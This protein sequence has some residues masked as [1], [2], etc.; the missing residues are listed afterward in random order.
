MFLEKIKSPEDLKKIPEK[1][2][3]VL[4]GEIRQKIIDTVNKNGG[5]MASNLGIVELTVALHRVFNS[6]Q[7]AII[8]DVS[9]QSYAHKLL[10]GRY[11]EFDTIRQQG[12]LSGFTR[13]SESS[14][15]Y[16]DAGHASSS[17]SSA[18]G[19]L[20]AWELQ[21]RNDKVAAVI[22]DGA[23]TGGMAFEAL[24]HAG[25]LSRNLIVILNDNKMS[26]SKNTGSIS[27]YLSRLTVT[28]PYQN[29]RQKLDRMIDAIPY[30]NRKIGKF[31]YR[32]KRG[33]KGLLLTN[34]LF[35][36]LGFEYVG[37]LDGHNIAQMEKMLKK[38]KKLP[39]PVVVHVVTKKGKG[40]APAEAH[41]EN[42]HGIAPAVQGNKKESGKSFTAAFSEKMIKLGEKDKK[43]CAITAAMAM[44]TGL[45][46]FSR[47]YPKRFFDV[48]I[49][50]EH[51]VTFAGGLAAGGLLP[52]CAIYSTFMQRSVDQVIEDLALQKRH[53]V[54][55]LDRAG[56][57][58]NDGETHQGIFDIALFKNVP[59]VTIMSPVSQKD[60]SACM[61]YAL[62]QCEG[63]V[64]LR[65]AKSNCPKEEKAFSQKIESGK[66][67]YL[68]SKNSDSSEK[69]K[70]I[71]LTGTPSLYP[72]LLKAQKL[73]IDDGYQADLYL[74]RFIK[75]FDVEYFSSIAAM[76]QA[77]LFVEDGVE[78]GSIAEELA[79]VLKERKEFSKIKT[80]ISAFPDDFVANGS[81]DEI[82]RAQLLDGEGIYIR[83]KDLLSARRK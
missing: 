54:L 69:A 75:P 74:L 40:Y 57:V 46:E 53:A 19:L 22:G 63:P 35:V 48:G 7:D 30:F 66:G 52:V 43:I 72:E 34:N 24:S 77:L 27:R 23:L 5:H 14:H 9:H 29:I 16:F 33:L 73:L 67:I 10:T 21:G 64:I 38:V 3:S 82:L 78:R 76:Y 31:I 62:Y 79:L 83:A 37:P 18:L 20:T 68:K 55:V 61:D 36:D 45:E 50:E 80:G 60:L 49:A 71:L 2:L 70:K 39:R 25:Q 47:L 51:A 1:N 11:E 13:I 41:P 65:W 42:F 4:S 56:A 44:G 58:A 32:F 59:G 81:R 28:K 17:I 12:G 15:D 6:P 8:F 26:I